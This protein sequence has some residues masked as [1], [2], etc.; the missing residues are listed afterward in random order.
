MVFDY[1]GKCVK[2]SHDYFL[3]DGNCV[4]VDKQSIIK[5]CSYY[6]N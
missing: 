5:G 6:K 2:C 3:Q 1:A 4:K